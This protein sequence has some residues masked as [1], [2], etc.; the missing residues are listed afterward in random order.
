MKKLLFIFIFSFLLFDFVSAISDLP[1]CKGENYK[2]YVNCYGSY[3]G[4]DYSKIYNIPGLTNNY[5]G[6][7][8]DLPGLAHGKGIVDNY[9]NGE[10]TA[11]NIGNFKNDKYD[12]LS[13]YIGSDSETGGSFISVA[14]WKEDELLNGTDFWIDEKFIYVGQFKDELFNGLGV[15]MGPDGWTYGTFKDDDLIN[16]N[17]FSKDLCEGQDRSKWN[18]CVV[19]QESFDGLN[20]YLDWGINK[21]SEIYSGEVK[22]DGKKPVFEGKGL[23]ATY[24]DGKLEY[25]YAGEFKN[26]Y[27]DGYG[28]DYDVIANK[29]YVGQFKRNNFHGYGTLQLEDGKTYVGYFSNNSYH[30]LGIIVTNDKKN[31]SSYYYG[32]LIYEVKHNV[33]IDKDVLLGCKSNTLD[34]Y[35]VREFDLKV[36]L[37]ENLNRLIVSSNLVSGGKPSYHS[38]FNVDEILLNSDEYFIGFYRDDE[39][40]KNFHFMIDKFSGKFKVTQISDISDKYLLETNGRLTLNA[41]CQNKLF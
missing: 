1:P 14:E 13:T 17:Y 7:F 4:K 22:F 8:G 26:G 12:G 18:N 29:I 33:Q 23:V 25:I 31:I 38:N 40:D 3:E 19:K 6:E 39:R 16:E 24:V 5:V 20:K 27:R 10:H 2:K 11:T 30:G 37:D 32:E 9:I 28:T 35:S 34:G 36:I 21:A 41:K 15:S